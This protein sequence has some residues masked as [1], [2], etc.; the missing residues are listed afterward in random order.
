VPHFHLS[1]VREMDNK[2]PKRLGLPHVPQLVGSHNWIVS[3]VAE[4]DIM[5]RC[6]K[7]VPSVAASPR[8]LRLG[9]E[10][11]HFQGCKRNVPN[12]QDQQPRTSRRTRIKTSHPS[13]A[14]RSIRGDLLCSS[15]CACSGEKPQHRHG[16]DNPQRPVGSHNHSLHHAVAA[17]APRRVNPLFLIDGAVVTTAPL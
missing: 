14:I 5:G 4:Q 12:A 6:P 16:G 8:A 2:W 10:F 13:A 7:S 3:R 15:F 11:P 17:A 1:T 9:G